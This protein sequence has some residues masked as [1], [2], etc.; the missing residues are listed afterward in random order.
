MGAGAAPLLPLS[1]QGVV[2]DL[3]G[4]SPSPPGVCLRVWW[5]A[6]LVLVSGGWGGDLENISPARSGW[7]SAAAE[8]LPLAFPGPGF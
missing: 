1:T 4:G 3:L 8:T 7:R 2:V 5:V 6:S